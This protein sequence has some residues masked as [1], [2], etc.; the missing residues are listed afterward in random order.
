MHHILP[1]SHL[2]HL[3]TPCLTV[4]T[5]MRKHSWVICRG[6][7]WAHKFQDAVDWHRYKPFS[8]ITQF[9]LVKHFLVQL[10]NWCLLIC[11]LGICILWQSKLHRYQ[12]YDNIYVLHTPPPHSASFSMC[13]CAFVLISKCTRFYLKNTTSGSCRWWPPWV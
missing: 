2:V 1:I 4:P 10:H 13:L 9:H 11:T 3:H 5:V 7:Y 12:E 8:R 6:Y